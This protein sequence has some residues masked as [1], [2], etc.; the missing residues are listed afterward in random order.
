VVQDYQLCESIPDD[1]QQQAMDPYQ[2]HLQHLR[3]LP[4]A[5]VTPCL[6]APGR[7]LLDAQQGY[8]WQDSQQQRQFPLINQALNPLLLGS[9]LTSSVVLWDGEQAEM[10]S[11]QAERWGGL[12]C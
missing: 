9:K 1:I 8:W 5:E 2:A 7:V 12:A 10:M 11:V 6:L 4:W 3:K